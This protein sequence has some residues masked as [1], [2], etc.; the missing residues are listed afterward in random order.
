MDHRD[1]AVIGG[2]RRIAYL[3]QILAR[4]GFRVIRYATCA[5]PGGDTSQNLPS[6]DTSPK[7]SSPEFSGA[8]DPLTAPTLKEAVTSAGTVICG[9]PLERDHA[10]N[11]PEGTG[12]I[13]L[14]ELQ[15]FLRRRQKFFGGVLSEDFRRHCEERSIECH[16][17]MEDEP[18]TL[19]NAIC[20]AEGA[21]LEALSHKECLLHQS[22]C[23]VLGYGRCGSLIAERLRGLCA[24]VFV[25]TENPTELALAQSKGCEAFPLKQLS[26]RVSQFDYLFN[27][28]PACYLGAD[29]LPQVRRD[30]LIIDVASGRLGVDYDLA[31]E[32]SLNALFCPGLPGK[33]A[34]KSCAERLA[35]YVMEN[36]DEAKTWKGA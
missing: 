9:I 4:E 10:L 36:L 22:S 25:T 26:S 33:Y 34:A 32:L 13:P 27:T 31:K 15:R 17:F 7:Q 1:I 19:F 29:C 3:A 20:T 35:K 2:D 24:R 16:D 8:T 23:L 18:L 6:G 12:R 5:L 11:C 28:I 21:I 30:C 14:T